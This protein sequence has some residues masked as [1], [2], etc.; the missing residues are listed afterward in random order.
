MVKPNTVLLLSVAGTL[1][2]G[3]ATRTPIDVEDLPP[4]SAGSASEHVIDRDNVGFYSDGNWSISTSIPGYQG[5]D[6]LISD[7]GTGSNVATWNLNIIR[8]FD[9]FAKWTSTSQRGS[10][11]KFV[12]YHLDANNNL[13]TDT[14]TVSQR[15]NGGT[16]VKLGTYRMSTLT[17]RVTV[18]NDADGWV[19]ADAVLFREAGAETIQ[20]G[21]QDS[22][23]D[24]ISDALELQ[25]GLDPNDPSDASMDMD[26]DGLSNKDEILL[27]LTDPSVADSDGDG[28]PDGFEVNYGLDPSVNDA[29]ADSDGDGISNFDEYKAGSDPNDSNSIPAGNYVLLT[30]T[31]PNQR[32]DGTS[33]ST[34]DIAYYELSY[35][36]AMAGEEQ[37]VDNDSTDFISYGGGRTSSSYKGYYGSSYFI[38]DPGSG[39]TTAEWQVYN[40]SPG[41]QYELYGYWVASA[42]R[43]SNATYQFTY[44][45]ANGKQVT[46]SSVVDQRDNGSTWQ[47]LGSFESSGGQLT[48]KIDNN[49]DG[50]VIAD[51]IKVSAA[52]SSATTEVIESGDTSRYIVRDLQQGEWQFQIRA[53]DSN[54]LTG[55]YSAPVTRTVE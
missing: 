9:V 25:Y 3:C 30:W 39:E 48:V 4:S 1:V 41:V 34:S 6:Y 29:A 49:A 44:T 24:G 20:P 47:L 17:G 31:P 26:G 15:E 42:R 46:T 35:Q 12:I 45:D 27:V 54:G 10:N 21:D 23:G 43:A 50:Y 36:M 22:D 53:T 19:V 51:A 52:S 13:T 11:V 38:M 7:P 55:E 37:I 2:A 14:V 5:S 28:I 40:L 18:S 16:W 33:L 32:A 8:T